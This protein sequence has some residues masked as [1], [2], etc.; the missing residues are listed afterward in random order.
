[1]VTSVGKPGTGIFLLKERAKLQREPQERKT[2][3]LSKRLCRELGAAEEQ[4]Q[5]SHGAEKTVNLGGGQ[6]GKPA[7]R[8]KDPNSMAI[9]K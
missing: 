4:K 1:M 2:F 7:D 6:A 3:T 9:D 8:K 5:N